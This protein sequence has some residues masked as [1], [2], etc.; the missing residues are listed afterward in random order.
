MRWFQRKPCLCLQVNWN[1]REWREELKCESGPTCMSDPSRWLRPRLREPAE[2]PERAV[3]GSIILIRQLWNPQEAQVH[4]ALWLLWEPIPMLLRFCPALDTPRD[5]PATPS[6]PS[7]HC[8]RSCCAAVGRPEWF[9]AKISSYRPSSTLSP[10]AAGLV[11]WENLISQDPAPWAVTR[12]G[13]PGDSGAPSCCNT[14]WPSAVQRLGLPFGEFFWALKNP[15]KK[16]Y[17]WSSYCQGFKPLHLDLDSCNRKVLRCAAFP[18]SG[19]AAGKSI[20]RGV[21]HFFVFHYDFYLL[22][23]RG[24]KEDLATRRDVEE[25]LLQRRALKSSSRSPTSAQ[26][27]LTSLLTFWGEMM[28]YQ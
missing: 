6:L 18:C 1:W 3:P 19:R 21:L 14:P 5:A 4:P 11:D 17:Q 16:K 23:G 9:Q 22:Q 2:L 15:Q 8:C 28:T 26:L 10:G 12:C 13:I 24:E 20:K 7:C 25:L 27:P